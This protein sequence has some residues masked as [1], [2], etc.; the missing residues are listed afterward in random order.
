M[1]PEITRIIAA[2]SMREAHA[3]A[4]DTAAAVTPASTASSLPQASSALNRHMESWLKQKPYLFQHVLIAEKKHAQKRKA[5][6]PHNNEA[7]QT[8]AAAAAASSSAATVAPASLPVDA[9]EPASVPNR[10]SPT[11]VSAA[12][13]AA[14]GIV[15]AVAARSANTIDSPSSL[16]PG[17]AAASSTDA[18]AAPLPPAWI[19]AL[20]SSG[21]GARVVDRSLLVALLRRAF[22]LKVEPASS[23]SSSAA[24]SSPDLAA[25]LS[26][27][28]SLDRRLRDRALE[29]QL[30]PLLP[31]ASW[32]RAEVPGVLCVEL[33]CLGLFKAL[34]GSHWFHV[35]W[36][37]WNLSAGA[38]S[39][40]LVLTARKVI[41]HQRSPVP[42]SELEAATAPQ[43]SN[44]FANASDFAPRLPGMAPI[45]M[46]NSM[47]LRLM[48]A[49][50]AGATAAAGSGGGTTTSIPVAT[51][52]AA[53]ILGGVTSSTLSL[54]P[55]ESAISRL[56]YPSTPS[57][58]SASAAPARPSATGINMGLRIESMGVGLAGR[59]LAM[60][61]G[62]ALAGVRSIVRIEG[63]LGTM[64]AAVTFT[65][66]GAGG[67]GHAQAAAGAG[68]SAA[69]ASVTAGPAGAQRSFT[70][71]LPPILL[72]AAAGNA[73]DSN[74]LEMP[75]ADE[76]PS[77]RPPSQNDHRNMFSHAVKSAT[78]AQ[79][80]AADAAA[81][82]DDREPRKPL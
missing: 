73:F 59:P 49:A 14:H 43:V 3:A 13:V 38:K 60:P 30:L 9:T 46:G 24:S 37:A 50:A 55:L 27:A 67:V 74:E 7:E 39:V 56:A 65:E 58:A 25:R 77:Y 52:A 35:Q 66:T 75:P 34:K 79:T 61:P 18:P 51:A 57:P 2:P 53:S 29:L 48:G 17:S 80:K 42:A 22:K 6:T 33:R 69:S 40:N 78:H 82:A 47:G 44:V 54:S 23:P 76:P 20:N 19:S 15:A 45:G 63:G 81:P 12:H 16:D 21:L 4:A 8:P 71:K 5:T 31:L 70:I 41:T 10:A 11:A 1:T 26:S 62:S 36:R 64:E 68:G 28:F 32:S 72:D